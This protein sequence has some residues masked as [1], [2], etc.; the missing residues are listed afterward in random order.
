MSYVFY[1]GEIVK[2]EE[3]SISMRCKAFNYGLGCFEGIRA[4]WNDEKK[5]LYVFRLREHYERLL[6][7]CK[8]LYIN[9][10][11]TVEQLCDYT[12]ELLRKNNF[13]TTVYIRPVAYKGSNELFPT[14]YD[15]DNRVLIYCQ[16]MGN[17]AGK[18]AFRVCVSSWRR[19]SDNMIPARTKPT[20]GYLNS[21]L[22]SLEALQNGYDEAILLTD[23]GYVC[24]GPGENIFIVKNNKLITPPPSDNILEGITR[25]TVMRIAKEE[26]GME[27]VERS[28]AR[29]ELYS[30]D[31]VFFSGTAMEVTSVVEVDNRKVGDGKPGKVCSQI[32]E[33]FFGL[34]TDNNPK[35]SHF[36][37][38][39]Y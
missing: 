24:E 4:Y 9:I 16:P 37:T 10:P 5:Q 33:Q 31:E 12:L 21:A 20:G 19:I 6:N 29:S 2:E 7:S 22:A 36:C 8:A 32:K 13:K 30:A 15:D 18:D 17:F 25:D 14:V 26:L 1:Q 35:Y 38:P 27:V 23:D 3:V 11:Y 28:I 34:T 39:V